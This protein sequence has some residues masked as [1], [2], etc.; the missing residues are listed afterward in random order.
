[1]EDL[2]KD[3]MEVAQVLLSINC[4]I[5]LYNQ[6]GKVV[7][8]CADRLAFLAKEQDKEKEPEENE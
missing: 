4:P 8:S 5:G 1:M 3:I 6:V 2:K 7:Q